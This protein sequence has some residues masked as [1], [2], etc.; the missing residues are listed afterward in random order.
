MEDQK[1]HQKLLGE[2][3]VDLGFISKNLLNLVLKFINPKNKLL[4]F[5]VEH[6]QKE[7]IKFSSYEFLYK[8][9]NTIFSTKNFFEKYDLSKYGYKL[10]EISIKE[11][12]HLD[13]FLEINLK[14]PN[15]FLESLINYALDFDV[16][17]FHIEPFYNFVR[18][19]ARK[20]GRLKYIL[21]FSKE[22]FK[23]FIVSLKSLA[24]LD[25]TKSLKPQD[26]RVYINTK[27]GKIFLRLSFLP[28][29]HGENLVIRVLNKKGSI[30]KL[31]H[32]GL[33][34]E[35][36]KKLKKIKNINHGLVLICGS[37]GSGKTTTLYA[38]IRD[39]F[40]P[41]K[42]IISIEDPVEYL[43]PAI[44]QI[45]VNE[46]LTYFEALRSSLRQD[47]D[48]IV[49]GEIRDENTAKTAIRA[50]QT[51]HLVLASLH[52]YSFETTISRLINLG[53]AKKD[54]LEVLKLI[55]IQELK[56]VSCPFCKGETCNICFEGI[57]DKKPILKIFENFPT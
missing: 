14:N 30:L 7:L 53:I 55:I 1:H 18:L 54:L 25:Y 43:Y 41:Q 47:P 37:T 49:L 9:G 20:L 17:D 42:N 56:D 21:N 46:K 24:N 39:L 33:E 29:I 27:K 36:Y 48:I 2:I 3:L 57:F 13:S 16:T 22:F 52:A 10:F 40:S 31:E 45:E 11:K 12:F 38:L 44:R 34:N 8:Y 6:F 51:G 26:G 4:N 5:E 23:R 32:L 15:Q 19:K 50:A 35:D 28:G